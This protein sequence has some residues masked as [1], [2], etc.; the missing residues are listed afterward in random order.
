MLKVE[1][2]PSS[3]LFLGDPLHPTGSCKDRLPGKNSLTGTLFRW[4]EGEIPR[5]VNVVKEKKTYV[6]KS[7]S[8][9]KSVVSII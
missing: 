5:L 9:Q 2:N 4:E 3:F 8:I 6:H 7:Y 1:P